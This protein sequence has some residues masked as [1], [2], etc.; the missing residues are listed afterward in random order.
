MRHAIRLGMAMIGISLLGGVVPTP[1]ARAAFFGQPGRIAFVENGRI[2]SMNSDGSDIK[3]LTSA[4]QTP[5]G[6]SD[7]AWSP[8]GTMIAFTR[9]TSAHKGEIWVM[10][11]DG[12]GQKRL[13]TNAVED[14]DPQ[15]APDGSRIIFA[16]DRFGDFDIL[17]MNPS[18]GS[19]TA[20][21]EAEANEVE[22]AWSPDGKTIAYSR[23]FLVEFDNGD[24]CEADLWLM[25]GD[26]SHE[27]QLLDCAMWIGPLA[28]DSGCGFRLTD[29]DWSPQGTEIVVNEDCFGTPI[30]WSMIDEDPL[31]QWT[32]WGLRGVSFSPVTHSHETFTPAVMVGG[33][34]QGRIQVG[35]TTG[36]T[37]DVI[38]EE[39]RPG[40]RSEPDWQ[41]IPPFP[42]VDARFSTFKADIEWVYAEGITLGCSA[43]RYCPEDPVTREQMAIFLDRALDLPPT[44]TDYFTDDEGRTGEASINRL[45]AAGITS[46]CTATTY[47][48]TANVTR[49]QMAS[50]LARAFNLPSTTTDYFSDDE[51]S[52]HEANINRNRA[53]GIT[54]G[55]TATT[56]CPK[57]LVTRGQM[58]AFLHRALD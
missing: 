22:P 9:D 29:P 32:I 42:L 25:D 54:T 10:K 8:G 41:P 35:T 34:Q 30:T 38:V 26:G 52:S 40:Y 53:A 57:G 44:T 43:E 47:C 20:L 56:Y 23:E 14:V 37:G 15:W 24:T 55:C 46:G 12:S 28:G 45:R 49:E 39:D 18:G 11:A 1:A 21:T 48:P 4:T 13:T 3:Q 33:E 7:P 16:S 17:T 6:D 2:L 50:F 36:V 31:W 58:A 27:R 51:S 19:I 5:Y